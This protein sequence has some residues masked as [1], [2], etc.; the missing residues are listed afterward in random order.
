[1]LTARPS[2]PT[3][4]TRKASLMASGPASRCSASTRMVKLSAAR[5]TA[6]LR[7]PTTSARPCPKE[8]VGLTG[9]PRRRA[10]RPVPRPTLS[11]IRSESMLN[12]SDTSA[13]ELPIDP[14]TSS[15][16]K[17]PAVSTSMKIRRHVWPVY[18]GN[19]WTSRAV[20]SHLAGRCST[21]EVFPHHWKPGPCYTVFAWHL[22]VSSLI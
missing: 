7:A 16:T 6:L 18:H 2:A 1:M 5:K 22:L 19:I 20:I 8:A 13:I 4:R 17:K 11:A 10:M 12:E 9:R 21:G 3:T 14:D 15:A